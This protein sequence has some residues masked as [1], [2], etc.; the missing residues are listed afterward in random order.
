MGDLADVACASMR[1]FSALALLTGGILAEAD[2]EVLQRR[3]ELFLLDLAKGLVED[4]VPRVVDGIRGD[5]DRRSAAELVVICLVEESK[6][7]RDDDEA[8]FRQPLPGRRRELAVDERA[9]PNLREG[10]GGMR[11]SVGRGVVE[12]RHQFVVT[13][14]GAGRGQLVS[15]QA[16]GRHE[17]HS[18]EREGDRTGS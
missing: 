7:R 1:A 4:Q 18:S 14:P 13:E 6:V 2:D 5:E 10:G 12:Q 16:D 8:L 9:D 11:P 3:E 15:S 17:Q